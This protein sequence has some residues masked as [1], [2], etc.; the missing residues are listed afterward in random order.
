MRIRAWFVTM[1]TELFDLSRISEQNRCFSLL[2]YELCEMSQQGIP[3]LQDVSNL[4]GAENSISAGL[5][6][7]FSKRTELGYQAAIELRG[8]VS[9]IAI[10]GKGEQVID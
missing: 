7:F 4:L 5:Q 2:R 1:A 8:K 9:H 10:A 3:A 6:F